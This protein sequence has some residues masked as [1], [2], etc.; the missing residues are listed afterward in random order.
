MRETKFFLIL[1]Y[2]PMGLL[3]LALLFALIHKYSNPGF[4]SVSAVDLK[5][6]GIAMF[7]NLILIVFLHL[8]VRKLK[9]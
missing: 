1:S 3:L 2:V 5:Y 9:K 8:V 6:L 7:C 4:K